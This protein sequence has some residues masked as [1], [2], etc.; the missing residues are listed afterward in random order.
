MLRLIGSGFVLAVFLAGCVTNG[1]DFPS[2]LQWI[3]KEQTRKD[4]V[5]MLLGDPYS[6]GN[7][8]GKSTWT[9][10]FYRYK[11]FGKSYTKELKFY[12]N[13]DG[14]VETFSFNS[15]FPT[16][17]GQKRKGPVPSK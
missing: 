17:T 3:Q 9:Y 2:D 1:K 5:K 16:D 14:T 10:G 15:S 4:E 11:L 12:W 7:S 8:G 6:V 13:P